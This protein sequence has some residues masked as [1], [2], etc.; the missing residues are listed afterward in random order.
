V[1]HFSATKRLA[2][3]VRQLQRRGADL[4]F[5]D[6]LRPGGR[7]HRPELVGE[8]QTD[9]GALPGGDANVGAPLAREAGADALHLVLPDRQVLG[10]EAAFARA[11]H[12]EGQAAIGVLEFHE[13]ANDRLAGGVVDD[14]LH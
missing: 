2:V 9:L 1:S 11:D 6:A 5:R 7:Q 4:V 14:A 8:Q 3:A 12:H 10:L 13:G